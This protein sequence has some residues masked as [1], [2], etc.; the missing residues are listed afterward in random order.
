MAGEAKHFRRAGFERHTRELRPRL[1]DVHHAVVVEVI[2]QPVG[3][4]E[5]GVMLAQSLLP[6]QFSARR[7]EAMRDARVGH[8]IRK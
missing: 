1:H 4:D 3:R 5:R 8:T 6:E 7:V 2:D